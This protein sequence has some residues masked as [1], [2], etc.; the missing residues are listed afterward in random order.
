MS[1]A[2]GTEIEPTENES[3]PITA[4]DETSLGISENAAGALS[5]LLGFVTG[6]IFYFVEDKNEFVRFHAIQSTIVFGG[7]FALGIALNV[8]GVALASI[9]VLG[10]VLALALG[11]ISLLLGPVA[12]ILWI[13]LMFK[14]YKGERFALPV[15]GTYAERHI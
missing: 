5:Y 3:R 11:L 12:L 13:V 8:A 9:P 1:T 2:S 10:L 15:V 14:A 4:A 6:L 7:L